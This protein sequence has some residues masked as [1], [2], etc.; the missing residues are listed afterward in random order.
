MVMPKKEPFTIG[1]DTC[2][3]RQKKTV[4]IQ[5]KHRSHH[6]CQPHDQAIITTQATEMCII[7]DM[8]PDQ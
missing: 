8:L 7:Q 6:L 1:K 2:R 3:R 5:G 4:Q